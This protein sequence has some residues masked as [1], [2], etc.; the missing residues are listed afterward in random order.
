MKLV[1]ANILFPFIVDGPLSSAARTL[2]EMDRDW[3]TE[4]FAMIELSN[5][6]ATYERSKKMTHDE[7]REFLSHAEELLASHLVTV[8]HEV[9]LDLASRFRVT[10]YDARYLAAAELLGVPLVTEDVRL[11]RAAPE[12]TQSLENALMEAR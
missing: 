10:A 4:S 8:P 5:V 1:D 12:L 3:R 11:R 2:R 6:L 7:A 9:A